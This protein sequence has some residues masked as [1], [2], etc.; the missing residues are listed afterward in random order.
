VTSYGLGWWVGEF[1]D[2]PMIGNYGA[3]AGFQS[4]LG[5]F[6]EQG[7]AV[8]AMVNA[9]DDT[10]GL[11]PAYAIG[12]EAAALLLDSKTE[13][14][15]D[16]ADASA[17]L[18]AAMTEAID[19]MIEETLARTGV[20]GLAI[21]VVKD[22]AVAYAKGYGTTSLDGGAPVNEQTVFQW[23]ENTM[24]LTAMAVM[25]LAEE[26]KINL[27][28]PV[29]DYVP[30][31]RLADERYKEV[32]VGQILAHASG[33]PETGD[34]MADWETF[35][36]EYDGGALNRWV[37][38]E[39]A[40]EG[41]LFAPGERFGYSDLAFA[42]LGAVIGA[43]SDQPYESYMHDHM[44]APLAM[45]RS[46]F[47]LEEVDKAKLAAPHVPDATGTL[48]V[49]AA[50]PYH[51]PYA[52]TNNLFS[53]VEDMAKLAQAALNR[54]ELDGHRILPDGAFDTMWSVQWATPFGDFPFGRHHPSTIMA[55]WGAGWFLGEVNGQQVASSYGG[56][57]GFNAA[58]ILAPSAKMGV[59][60]VGN[61]LAVEE[62]FAPDIAVD[63]LG[64]LLEEEDAE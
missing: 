64:M 15:A 8:V 9:Y 43:A 44:F 17:T 6:P 25:Q 20:P 11:V 12:N 56:E 22:G 49:S 4:H 26:G 7:F 52:A 31:F 59:V 58:M 48:A 42:L 19:A 40:T 60:V 21:A 29:T 30:Y 1:H 51:R 50:L 27:D 33:I 16:Q 3:E 35:V 62:Y 18:D 45:A 54:G 36:P 14:A 37:R 39:L 38:N 47:L 2:Q 23:A 24:A 57:H 61:G 10:R 63:V 53:S 28:A 32:T 46:T 5:I 41:L 34:A 13:A 55:D